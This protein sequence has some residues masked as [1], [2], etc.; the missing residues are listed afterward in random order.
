VAGRVI[1]LGQISGYISGNHRGFEMAA[2]QRKAV[3]SY[4]GR[5]KRK[6]I[7]RLEVHV[8]KADAGLVRSVARALSD[9][10]KEKETRALLRARFGTGKMKGLKALLAAAPLEDVDLTREHDLGRDID[11]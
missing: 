8:K 7:T 3:N 6:G 10:G 1:A 11:L 5:L 4:R 9:P 2:A